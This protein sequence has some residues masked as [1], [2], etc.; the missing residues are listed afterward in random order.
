MGDWWGWGSYPSA[1]MGMR[2][3]ESALASGGLFLSHRNSAAP[4]CHRVCFFSRTPSTTLVSPV[5]NQSEVSLAGQ[6]WI[7]N[8]C[9]VGEAA[10]VRDGEG[11]DVVSNGVGG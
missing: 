7:G 2:V 8:V 1:A 5:S 4:L 6:A 3:G 9:F 10:G 11:E